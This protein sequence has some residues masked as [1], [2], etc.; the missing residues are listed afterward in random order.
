VKTVGLSFGTLN[1]V[2]FGVLFHIGFLPCSVCSL[3]LLFFFS[4]Y[5]LALFCYT[6]GGYPLYD[7]ADGMPISYFN[8]TLG[9]R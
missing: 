2:F 7:D 9:D 4:V 6:I 1:S 8:W 5:C 3:F